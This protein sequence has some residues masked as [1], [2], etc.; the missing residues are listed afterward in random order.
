[1]KE[2]IVLGEELD[3]TLSRPGDRGAGRAAAGELFPGGLAVSHG[4]AP[5]EQ[6]G[7]EAYPVE[8]LDAFLE[9]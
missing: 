9:P 8:L 7:Y 6:S 1:V 3:L 4:P 5:A 2:A